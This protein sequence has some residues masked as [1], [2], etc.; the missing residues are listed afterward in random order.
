M[1]R[2]IANLDFTSDA[3]LD[4]QGAPAGR[5]YFFQPIINP[6]TDPPEVLVTQMYERPWQA[7]Y[8]PDYALQQTAFGPG[9][10][11]ISVAGRALDLFDNLVPLFAQLV[12]GQLFTVGR[13]LGSWGEQF[14]YKAFRTKVASGTV[15]VPL[16]R[17]LD[18]LDVLVGLNRRTGP[19]PLVYGCRYV[20]KS[21][22]L[23][24]FNR[25]NPTFVISI[26]GVWNAA[27]LAFFDRIPAAM[28]AAG[29]EFTQHW[30]KTNGYT[31]ERIDNVFAADADRW[32]AARRRLLPDPADRALFANDFLRERGL[33]D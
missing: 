6:N 22:A 25:W 20:W 31:P 29:I 13:T 1:R 23:L 11:F 18:T 24:A 10:D 3:L 4:P 7:G 2:R 12:A 16:A 28:D 19:V 33:A 26:D 14:G 5:P 15:A 30:G 17:A 21:P 32:R 27:S 8:V 9:Y